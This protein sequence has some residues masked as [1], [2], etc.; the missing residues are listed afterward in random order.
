MH[1]NDVAVQQEL[2]CNKAGQSH[3]I[4]LRISSA[5]SINSSPRRFSVIACFTHAAMS[6]TI[7]PADH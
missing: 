7:H 5:F 3:C 4:K 2:G 6:H 1:E